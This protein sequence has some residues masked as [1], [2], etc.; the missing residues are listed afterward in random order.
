MVTR[1]KI[2]EIMLKRVYPKYSATE[3]NIPNVIQNI[4]YIYTIRTVIRTRK[5][6]TYELQINQEV[7]HNMRV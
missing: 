5:N 4:Y 6:R 2:F 1:G 3:L 7:T